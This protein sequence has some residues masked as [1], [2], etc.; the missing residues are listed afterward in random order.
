MHAIKARQSVPSSRAKASV[1]QVYITFMID[2]KII[3]R[4][5]IAENT[6]KSKKRI[7]C[8]SCNCYDP[9]SLP[10]S[11][12]TILNKPKAKSKPF[13]VPLKYT[14]HGD[15]SMNVVRSRSM[16]MHLWFRVPASQQPF[17]ERTRAHIWT[18][19]K[20]VWT[21][22]RTRGSALHHEHCLGNIQPIQLVGF[23]RNDK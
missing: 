5:T 15:L 4:R 17:R 13:Q 16:W 3:Q 21:N 23:Y 20:W 14:I 18:V 2:N 9:K 1:R 6:I 10:N 8:I 19:D 11:G 7:C 22:Q 12:W